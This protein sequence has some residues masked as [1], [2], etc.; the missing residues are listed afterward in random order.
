[1][2]SLF[3]TILN[4]SLT[5]AFVIMAVCLARL[6][7][8]RSPKIFLYCLWAVA[9]FR[10]T[11][12][13]SIES[14]F[15]LLPFDAQPIAHVYSDFSAA[16]WM[17][18]A[19]SVWLI[20]AFLMLLYGVAS[21]V[22]LKRKLKDAVN[23]EANIYEAETVK[24]PFVIGILSPKIYLPVYLAA[25][26]RRYIILHEQAHV[27]R[28]DHIVKFAAYLILCLHWFNPL[29][30]L[31]FLLMSLDMEMSCDERVLKQLGGSSKVKKDYSMAL[32]SLA[33][34]R[35]VVG[36]SV[37]AFIG[38]DTSSRVKNVLSLKKQS[39]IV[40]GISMVLVAAMSV[41]FAVNRVSAGPVSHDAG[42]GA[43]QSYLFIDVMCCN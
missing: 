10:L 35:S 42:R 8:K 7:L 13:F 11:F 30:W 17:T 39:Y 19:S 34:E 23:V 12:P 4:M 36:G 6:V 2:S 5:G 18:V 41:G 27:R 21:F 3:I 14:A 38:S 31:A 9:G 29:A 20:G 26:E 25:Q 28:R 22:S 1:M 33:T 37:L 16:T 40:F 24:T 15:S 43:Q 32:L